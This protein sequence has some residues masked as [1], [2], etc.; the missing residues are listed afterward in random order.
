MLR[1]SLYILEV[2][3][4][5]ACFFTLSPA[6]LARNW[7]PSRDGMKAITTSFKMDSTRLELQRCTGNTV[8]SPV[9]DLTPCGVPCLILVLPF[10]KGP[11][12]RISPHELH[13]NDPAF[14]ETAYR[15]DGIWHKYAW[16]VDAFAASGASIFTADHHVHK[17]R[18]QPL[19]PLF[20]KAR[21]AAHQDMIHRH[22]DKLCDRFS[23]FY[24][25]NTQFNFGASITALAR[26]VAN[27]FIL[28]K[29]YNSL[30][31]EDFD[32]DMTIASQGG[33]SMWR[34]TKHVRFVAPLMMSLPID[35][36]IKIADQRTKIFFRHL[37]VSPVADNTALLLI[38]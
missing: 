10:R 29:S 26:D 34:L 1:Q 36:V 19:G 31:H 23:K 18:R 35:W 15:Q 20:S 30:E 21:I 16:A 4:S 38:C 13:V 5:T 25:S 11:I 32:I 28:G 9:L 27:D 14:I 37:K 33:A 22:L 24:H 3:H 17:A 6:F 8:T 2:L 7:L 12:I